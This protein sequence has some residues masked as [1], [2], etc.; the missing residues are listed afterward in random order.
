MHRAT[1]LFV[2][3]LLLPSCALSQD[4]SEI[5]AWD[6]LIT[7][8]EADYTLFEAAVR[9]TGY[10]GVLATHGAGAEGITVFAPNDAA[11]VATAKELGYSGDDKN[12]SFTAIQRVLSALNSNGSF[13]K[14]LYDVIGYHVVAGGYSPQMLNASSGAL[15]TYSGNLIQVA[16][17]AVKHAAE[18]YLTNP[19]YITPVLVSNG[20]IYPINRILFPFIVNTE[21]TSDIINSAVTAPVAT[22]GDD[23]ASTSTAVSQENR[24]DA[25]SVN[26]NTGGGGGS[27][28]FPAD[29]KIRLSDGTAIYIEEVR[30]GDEVM[31]NEAG[32][33]S[34]IF[35]FTHKIT[36]GMYEFMRILA[37]DDMQIVLS[38][39]HYI[40]I[41]SNNQAAPAESVSVGDVLRTMDG[42]K[43]VLSIERGVRKRG[44]LAPHSIHGD[45]VVSGI[46]ASCYTQLLPRD[47]AHAALAPIR[48]LVRFGVEEP[49][50]PVF[51]SGFNV[52]LLLQPPSLRYLKHLVHFRLLVSS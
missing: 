39:K 46:V 5:S 31:V 37:E 42:P 22:G 29:E 28:C 7:R 49:L 34:R 23:Q 19:A 48:T 1:L 40:Y 51:Y 30:A 35:A 50:G 17:S 25:A 16:D 44:L 45:I 18:G 24:S 26:A 15:Q 8:T 52:R 10:Q 33:S 43:R 11:F 41:N 6:F 21:Q 3:L 27:V 32:D 2:S 47:A 20:I 4:E 9:A 14:P 12:G 38:A 13:I 36:H